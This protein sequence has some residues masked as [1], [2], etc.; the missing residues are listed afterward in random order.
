MTRGSARAAATTPER[1]TTPR[2]PRRPRTG[3]RRP[4]SSGR[5]SQVGV[6]AVAVPGRAQPVPAQHR[7]PASSASSRPAAASG[8]LAVE[9]DPTEGAVPQPRVDVLRLGPPVDEHLAVE[10]RTT[11]QVAACGR[12]SRRTR[13]RGADRRPAQGV[14]QGDELLR[15]TPPPAGERSAGSPGASPAGRARGRSSRRRRTTPA[16]HP[17]EPPQTHPDHDGAGGHD[18]PGGEGVRAAAPQC[19]DA[20]ADERARDERPSRR[21]GACH[22]R[23]LVVR[24]P[25]EQH[26]DDDGE[27]VRDQRGRTGAHRLIV[28]L[29]PT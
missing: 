21:D 25:P 1:P 28:P 18:R 22:R 23:P 16:S 13:H 9:H 27:Q 17:R 3:R 19:D 8:C 7:H 11:T 4:R 20:L 29:R 24:P 6:Q 15:L 14:V 26:E 10:R 5:R 2:P 12:F